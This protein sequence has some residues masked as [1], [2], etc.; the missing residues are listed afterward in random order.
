MTHDGSMYVCHDH[1]VTFTIN[2]NPI[3]FVSIYLS[4]IVPYIHTDPSWVIFN[5]EKSLDPTKI[6]TKDTSRFDVVH[7]CPPASVPALRSLL[8]VNGGMKINENGIMASWPSD[9][10]LGNNKEPFSNG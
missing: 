1:G 3:F 9:S 4:T 2:K 5:R 10:R 6:A 7:C 8:D